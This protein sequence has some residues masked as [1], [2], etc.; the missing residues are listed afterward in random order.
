MLWRK[1][2]WSCLV[3]AVMSAVAPGA[4][5][6]SAEPKADAPIYL[7]LKPTFV[8][9]YGGVGRLRYLKADLSVR[10]TNS[11]TANSIRHHLPYIRNNLVMLLASQTDASLESQAGKEALRQEAL[12]EVRSIL[13]EEDGQEGV[14]DIYFDNLV[15][16]K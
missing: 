10:V 2:F 6:Q 12:A 9:N 1:S 5:A 15:I 4:L 14:V 11:Q 13:L 8:V 16:Q 7:P 3:L